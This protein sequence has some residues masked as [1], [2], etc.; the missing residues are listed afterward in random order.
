MRS[1]IMRLVI[2]PMW[3]LFLIPGTVSSFEVDGIWYTPHLDNEN[4]VLV[5]SMNKMFWG[6]VLIPATVSYEGKSYTVTGIAEWAFDGCV[7]LTSVELPPTLEVIGRH[8][9]AGCIRLSSL[10]F[11]SSLKCIDEY[12]FS[13]CSS[14]TSLALP[15]T[16]DSIGDYVFSGCS[17]L[18]SLQLPHGSTKMGDEVF[19]HCTGLTSLEIPSSWDVITAGA[20]SGCTGLASLKLPSTLVEIKENSFSGCTGLVSLELPPSL[21]SI[22]A[23][24]FGNC[25]GLTSVKMPDSLISIGAYAFTGCI[26]LISMKLPPVLR[27]IGEGAFYGC[28]ALQS[29]VIPA[30]IEKMGLWVFRYDSALKEMVVLSK[31]EE[32]ISNLQW[33]LNPCT[34]Y[35]V[36]EMDISNMEKVNLLNVKEVELVRNR[37]SFALADVVDIM[38]IRSLEMEGQYMEANKSSFY[39]FK[40]VLHKEEYELTVYADIYGEI[41]PFSLKI[42]SQESTDV[43]GKKLEV[44]GLQ[45]D[46]C[47]K[48]IGNDIWLRIMGNGED[49]KWSLVGIGG[50]IIETG[51]VSADSNWHMLNNIFPSGGFYLL[52]ICNGQETRSFKLCSY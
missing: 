2:L 6:D 24:A 32:V 34:I 28:S 39:T 42:T 29:I 35:G 38:Q 44:N 41:Y 48:S 49:V 30:S 25:R 36:P 11:P 22:R 50:E 46:L 31:D 3:L 47:K 27:E 20:F 18:T 51:T 43:P 4:E 8:A 12:A 21:K 19:L 14:L 13:N 7:G 26:S 16:L 52:S 37:L 33:G 17:G 45:V 40:N 10:E 15:S 5:G 1:F 23:N 9:F